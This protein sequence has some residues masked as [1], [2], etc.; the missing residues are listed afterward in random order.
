M[1]LSERFVESMT[2]INKSPNDQAGR[3][4]INA[5]C[6][7]R[8]EGERRFH[9]SDMDCVGQPYHWK[10]TSELQ[11][12]KMTGYMCYRMI[13]GPLRWRSGER[14]FEDFLTSHGKGLH[15]SRSIRDKWH[16][17]NSLH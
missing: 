6:D 3:D 17:E 8:E 2:V 9:I 7:D 1:I 12:A 10:S 14:I 13:E 16:P 15:I 4:E 5:Q 11:N